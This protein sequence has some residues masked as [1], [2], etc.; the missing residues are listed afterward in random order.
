MAVRK[1]RGAP[2]GAQIPFKPH[3][4]DLGPD[5]SGEPITTLVIEWD[6]EVAGPKKTEGGAGWPRTLRVFQQ[7]LLSALDDHG[8]VDRPFPDGPVV[9]LVDREHV[10]QEFYRRLSVD[11]D[12]ET[13]RQNARRQAFS[14]NVKDAQ[15]RQLI[16][17]VV[18]SDVTLLWIAQPGGSG[19]AK[20]N[21]IQIDRDNRDSPLDPV[22]SRHVTVQGLA[23]QMS[24][25]VTSRPSRHSQKWKGSHPLT[26]CRSMH[27]PPGGENLEINPM[28]HSV[29]PSRDLR[30]A[31]RCGA[32]RLYDKVSYAVERMPFFRNCT[33][34]PPDTLRHGRETALCS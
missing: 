5:E 21:G 12:S 23:R 25:T 19:A 6:P 8:R 27:L 16:G 28:D 24:Q 4:V 10:R 29:A 26:L 15:E 31:P 9:R 17:I 2:T 18:P 34:R 32:K 30:R 20:T 3:I 22:T 13:K 11:G 1:L 33:R 14:R 7:A